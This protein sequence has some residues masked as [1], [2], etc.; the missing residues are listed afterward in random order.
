MIY[1]NSP[2]VNFDATGLIAP[3]A[4]QDEQI[5]DDLKGW[6]AYGVISF[7]LSFKIF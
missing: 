2:H 1:Q 4:Q 5:E 3:T 7:G 6:K